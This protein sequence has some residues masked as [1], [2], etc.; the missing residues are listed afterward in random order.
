MEEATLEEIQTRIAFLERA[1][2]EISDQ[3]YR[4]HLEIA[5]LTRQLA[6]LADRLNAAMSEERGRSPDEERPPHY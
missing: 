1:N 2:T 3:L 5:A 4:Q 6:Q